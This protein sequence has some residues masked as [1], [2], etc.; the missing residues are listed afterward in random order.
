MPEDTENKEDPTSFALKAAA[1]YARL[2]EY[3]KYQ[4]DSLKLST[5]KE[6]QLARIE[7]DRQAEFRHVASAACGPNPDSGCF[8]EYYENLIANDRKYKEELRSRR[9]KEGLFLI[10]GGLGLIAIGV[11]GSMGLSKL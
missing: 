3:Y 5:D 4:A 7:L 8:R 11:I 2:R 6:I 9:R 10:K 1:E